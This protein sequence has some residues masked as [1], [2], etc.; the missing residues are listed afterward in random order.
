MWLVVFTNGSVLANE[1][2]CSHIHGLM[3]SEVIA[4]LKS[5]RVSIMLK[6][7]SFSDEIEDKLVGVRG[8]AAK[9][10]KV[11]EL[12]IDA[13]FN[14]PPTFRSDEEKHF[15]T[16]SAS[17][18]DA[19]TWTRLGLESVIT[20]QCIKDM[21]E[22]YNL[23]ATR[24][25]YI[26]LDPPVPVGLTR[27]AEWRKKYGLYMSEEQMLQAAIK[28]Y[29]FN[30]TLGIPFEGAS[31][32]FGGLPCSQLPYGLYVNSRGRLYPCCGCP[33]GKDIEDYNYL[34]NVREQGA[35]RK[36]LA[37]NPYHNHYKNH[38][39]AYDSPPFNSKE[40]KGYGIFHGCPFRD[41]A[42]DLMPQNWEM[43]VAEHIG[44]LR[45]GKRS[46]ESE[47]SRRMHD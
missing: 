6:F 43:K 2:Q 8:Y 42:G 4:R 19:I 46:T 1:A 11:L 35:L 3:P 33:D 24:R 10:N 23:K 21:E 5:R 9:R 47:L 36:A 7:H 18:E 39:F 15:M 44:H 45:K 29:E 22:I 37:T 14:A 12:L 34:G 41:K 28:L 26:D 32:Y 25:L 31:P 17:E 16:G 27:T 38:G 40:C 30:E 20:P 13:G